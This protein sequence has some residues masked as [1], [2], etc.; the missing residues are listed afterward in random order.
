[1]TNSMSRTITIPTSFL[2]AG[3]YV[4]DYWQDAKEAEKIP[5]KLEKKK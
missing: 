1:M 2:A 5:A 3:K 4:L